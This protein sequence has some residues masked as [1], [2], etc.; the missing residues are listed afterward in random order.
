MRSSITMVQHMLISC[1][2]NSRFGTG[3]KM[4]CVAT[5]A[6]GASSF[7]QSFVY[8]NHGVNGGAYAPLYGPEQANPFV[9]KWGNTSNAYPAGTQTYSGVPLAGSN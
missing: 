3:K 9:Q 5:V 1:M 4:L 6:W 7:S 8:S 2:K